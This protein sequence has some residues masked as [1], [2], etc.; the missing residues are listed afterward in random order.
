MRCQYLYLYSKILDSKWVSKYVIVSGAFHLRTSEENRLRSE[1][2]SSRTW[3]FFGRFKRLK[4]PQV[5]Y[6]NRSWTIGFKM[7]W[8]FEA[9]LNRYARPWNT[10]LNILVTVTYNRARNCKVSLSIRPRE[11]KAATLKPIATSRG[12][13]SPLSQD[14]AC[15]RARREWLRQM[16]GPIK[17]RSPARYIE[18]RH[19]IDRSRSLSD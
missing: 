9:P 12:G 11:R 2:F 16:R 5:S 18:S 17:C 15:A 14:N 8:T 10:K 1:M 13:F 3:I 7:F 6:G 4:V 19:L